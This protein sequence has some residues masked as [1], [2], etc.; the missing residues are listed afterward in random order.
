MREKHVCPKCRHNRI[1]MIDA[2][3]FI[4]PSGAIGHAAIA[5]T[6]VG[7]GFLGEKLGT[8]G[9]LSAAVCRRCGFTELY[10]LAPES[11]EVDDRYIREVV[12]PEQNDPYR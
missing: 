9:L 8:T 5:K 1:L 10:T 4:G 7:E 12:G 3:P 11:I 6:Y 2:V